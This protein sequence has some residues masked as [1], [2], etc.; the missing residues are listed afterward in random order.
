MDGCPHLLLSSL[1]GTSVEEIARHFDSHTGG[2]PSSRLST[3][4]VI[5][6]LRAAGCV[7]VEEEADQLIGAAPD[8]HTLQ[9]WLAR[10][11]QGE[12]LA[13]ITGATWFCGRSVRV[14][15]GVYVPR[16]Q[17]EQL[18]RRAA[19]LLPTK[20]GRVADLCTGS[21]AIAVYLAAEVPE[22]TVVGVDN[23]GRAVACARRNG[24]AAC[25]GDL[26]R[27]LRPAVFDVVTAVA[28]YVPT[29]DLRFLPADVQRYEPR[30]ALDG[31]P[32]GLSVLRRVVD[33][34]A[35]LLRR[36]GWLLTE[37]GGDEDEALVPVLA[38]KGFDSVGTWLDED[39]DLRGLAAR[40]TR[41]SRRVGR[42]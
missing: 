13:W 5:D 29:E 28:P 19:A 26:H 15:R 33:S 9:V 18:A 4:D 8:G 3:T 40:R 2:V 37:L 42:G 20:G 10:R 16:A 27:P 17:S 35:H 6:R 22:S 24:V 25:I 41:S 1:N 34:A 21:G 12:P 38:A 11:E 31:G 30:S 32:D 23:D 7:A 14:D 39:G 36:G